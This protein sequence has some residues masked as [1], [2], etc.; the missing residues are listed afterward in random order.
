VL[1]HESL[2]K[3]GNVLLNR[4]DLRGSPVRSHVN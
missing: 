3:E 4:V 2:L 1:F